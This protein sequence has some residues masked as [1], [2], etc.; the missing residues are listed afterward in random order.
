M[1]NKLFFVLIL[2]I[3]GN[4]YG[5][6]GDCRVAKASISGSYTGDCKNGLAHGK[7]IAQGIDRYEGEFTKGLPSGTG[8][9]RWA[10]GVYY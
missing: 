5:Q 3:G 6:T 7:G 1:L 10:D 4:I 9:Y 2:T 8:I